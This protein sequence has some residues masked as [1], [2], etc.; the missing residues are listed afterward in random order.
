MPSAVKPCCSAR[1]VRLELRPDKWQPIDRLRTRIFLQQHNLIT[2]VP[3][4]PSTTAFA[5]GQLHVRI[6]VEGLARAHLSRHKPFANAIASKKKSMLT[7]CASAHG[8]EYHRPAHRNCRHLDLSRLLLIVQVRRERIAPLMM[9]SSCS[10][11]A[12]P[13]N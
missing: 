9:S 6:G 5:A 12:P 13:E 4:S 10:A 8:Q 1:I 2:T 11:V 3:E 7:E